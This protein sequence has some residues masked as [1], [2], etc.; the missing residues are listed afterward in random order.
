MLVC[1]APTWFLPGAWSSHSPTKPVGCR[2]L[3]SWC[4][5]CAGRPGAGAG[6]LSPVT[7][8]GLGFGPLS[9]LDSACYP[10]NPYLV[11]DSWAMVFPEQYCSSWK[12]WKRPLWVLTTSCSVCYL[13]MARCLLWKWNNWA[14]LEVFMPFLHLFML[15]LSLSILW[16]PPPRSTL[17][18]ELPHH[19]P[20]REPAKISH[21]PA[22]AGKV[23]F[24][25]SCKNC[26]KATVSRHEYFI[27][28]FC[29]QVLGVM[30]A[31]SPSSPLCKSTSELFT[32]HFLPTCQ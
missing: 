21:L 3:L 13:S 17:G 22:R 19:P 25:T 1:Q 32:L 26:W 24:K 31:C 23:L 27:F 20:W 10:H 14:P 5:D 29:A 7:A 6:I 12:H 11:T 15:L 16:F 4:R 2:L 30:W 28:L 9:V 8:P 18:A